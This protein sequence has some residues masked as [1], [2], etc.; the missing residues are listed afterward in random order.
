MSDTVIVRASIELPVAE[1]VEAV[2]PEMARAYGRL[3]EPVRRRTPSEAL[4]V[5]VDRVVNALNTLER[6]INTSGEAKAREQMMLAVT[7]LRAVRT[8]NRSA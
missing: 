3:N 4:F 8:R 6:N 2:G 7:G 1:I 5:A